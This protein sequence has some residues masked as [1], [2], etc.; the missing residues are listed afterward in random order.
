MD[1]QKILMLFGAAAVMAAL[2]TWFLFAQTVAAKPEARKIVIAASH[3]LPLGAVLKKTDLK[4]VRVLEHDIPRGAI[5]TE[6]EALRRVTLFP[7]NGNEPLTTTKLSVADGPEGITATIPAGYRAVSVP[8]TDVSG[9]SGLV[10]PGSRVDVLFTRP[11]SMVEAITSTILQNVR[12]LAVGRAIVPNQVVDPKASKMPVA[13]LLVKPEDA[14]KIELA[15]NEGKLSLSLRNPLDHDNNLD[16]KPMT[17][18]VLDPEIDRGKH[19]NRGGARTVNDPSL[20]AELSKPVPVKPKPEP[21]PPPKAV[22]DVYRGDKHVQ[23]IFH[24]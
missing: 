15:K 1:R 8:I 2:L 17:T 12:V 16:G 22:I 4:Q 9:V 14:Q 20:L 6:Q 18:E 19:R 10:Q 21:P 5:F 7:V 3:D 13:T 11:G 24:D 23:E